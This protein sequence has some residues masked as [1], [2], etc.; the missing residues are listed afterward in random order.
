MIMGL[1]INGKNIGEQEWQPLCI[2]WLYDSQ[3]DILE[4]LDQIFM[5][6]RILYK[7]LWLYISE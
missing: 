6:V 1:F 5:Y 3:H 2:I 4:S 7:P